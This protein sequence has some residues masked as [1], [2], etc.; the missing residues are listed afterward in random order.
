MA[1]NRPSVYSEPEPAINNGPLGGPFPAY[2]RDNMKP[3]DK[4]LLHITIIGVGFGMFLA[5]ILTVLYHV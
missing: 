1:G 3:N 2:E 5:L 4:Y